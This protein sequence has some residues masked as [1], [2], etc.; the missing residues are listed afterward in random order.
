M[1]ISALMG[2]GLMTSESEIMPHVSEKDILFLEKIKS[3]SENG[4]MTKEEYETQKSLILKKYE[5]KLF[6]DM[7]SP[8]ATNTAPKNHPPKQESN[9][10]PKVQV[11]KMDLSKFDDKVD[12]SSSEPKKETFVVKKLDTSMFEKKQE[13]E[14]FKKVPK[15]ETPTVVVDDKLKEEL[16]EKN[17]E[18]EE[19][20]AK[21]KKREEE[22][23]KLKQ[24]VQDFEDS[25]EKLEIA[26]KKFVSV[27]ETLL[28]E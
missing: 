22:I 27:Q 11:K 5:R 12:A 3:K 23:K 4:L 20:K 15:K 26:L 25:N 7:K 10:A 9:P 28:K 6:G 19:L 16:E 13:E 14:T 2:E 24:Q 18:I 17:E 8:R 21:L 1:S